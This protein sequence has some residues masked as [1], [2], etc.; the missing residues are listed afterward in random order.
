[1]HEVEGRCLLLRAHP[2]IRYKVDSVNPPEELGGPDSPD[3]VLSF[4][5]S[6]DFSPPGSVTFR[7]A[8]GGSPLPPEARALLG[9]HPLRIAP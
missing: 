5:L 2:P 3:N 4:D 9:V 6:Y 1:M 7:P 8:D